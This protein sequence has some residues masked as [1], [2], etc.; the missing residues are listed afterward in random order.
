MTKYEAEIRRTTGG[1]AHV[2][3]KDWGGLGFGQGYACATDNLGTIWDMATRVRS[4]R[5]RYWGPGPEGN[6]LAADLGYLALGITAR[7]EAVREA[8]SPEARA[9]MAG[10]VAGC[11][12]RL[13]DARE[14]GS[15]P[16]WCRDAEW[17]HPL[18]ELDLYRMTVDTTMMA[19]GRN[20]VGLIGRAEAPGPEGPCAP[21]PLSAL[22]PANAASNGWA[23]G[24]EATA[25]GGGLVVANPHFPWYGE[26]RFWECHLTIPGE[27]DTYGVS[28]IGMPGVQLGFNAS[29]GWTHTFSRG[30][31][32]TLYR[33]ELDP[34]DPTRYRFGD[35]ERAMT[36]ETFGVQV[37]DGGGGLSTH[38]RTLWSSHHGPM[39]NLPLLGWGSEAAYTMRDANIDNTGVLDLFLGMDRARTI[40]ELQQVCA[41]TKA[42]PWLHT[43]AADSSGAVYY[44]DF[45]ATP[46]LSPAAQ[47]RYL[48]RLADD[49]V[50]AMLA[51]NQVALLDGSE[52][53]DVW[54]HE[55]GA[56]S[57]GLVPHDRLPSLTRGDVV[58]NCNDSHW[59]THPDSPLEGYSVMH[60]RERTPRT[61]RTRQNLI[62]TQ[63]LIGSGGVTPERAIDAILEGRALTA[64]LLRDEV[65]A[66]LRE[67][68]AYSQ[69]ADMLAAWDGTVA[70]ASQGGVLWREFLASFTPAQ[71]TDAGPLFAEPFDPDNPVVTPHGLAPAPDG[72]DPVV[73]AMGAALAALE[74]AGI[75]PDAALGSVQWAVAGGRHIGVPGGSEVEGAANV[76][77]PSGALPS[78]SLA[79]V[80]ESATPYAVRGTRTGLAPG[81]YQVAYGTGFL[82]AVEITA[83]G[84]R[85]I[86]LLAY[87]QSED[88]TSPDAAA[89]VRNLAES[90]L[91]PLCFT[92]AEISSDPNLS[93]S[94]VGTN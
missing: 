50:A 64:L 28:L 4:E 72:D 81:G 55:P 18:E 33:L 23:F 60:G 14:S 34:T 73:A 6:H 5:A 1:V 62:E 10:Y 9:V 17:L 12:A 30:N 36:A 85:G 56:R 19:S 84:P 58:V 21:A 59:L 49:P 91:R 70:V 83:D 15:L 86:G 79:P 71:L 32:F 93:R 65:V 20:L 94:V 47:R 75:A 46:N 27:L 80:P 3:S 76:L 48:D 29:L 42:M 25:S 82:M 13:E 2:A 8:V 37:A 88:F 43:M 40:A 16:D 69:A 66:R 24:R 89:Q 52:P 35:E 53:D 45:S 38:R 92:D 77:T 78:Q 11:N 39:V 31:R 67:V 61:L 63:R 7:A 90:R 74:A 22:G 41:T 51:E 57:P 26:A 68:G 44:C 54:V 87:G